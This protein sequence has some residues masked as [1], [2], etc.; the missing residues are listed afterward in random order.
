MGQVV[1]YHEVISVRV[2]GASAPTNRPRQWSVR[3][4]EA[5]APTE[6]PQGLRILKL[7]PRRRCALAAALHRP[8]K[9]AAYICAAFC[10]RV[11]HQRSVRDVIA[12]ATL[13]WRVLACFTGVQPVARVPGR[14]IPAG[15]AN[16]LRLFKRLIDCRE[17]KFCTLRNCMYG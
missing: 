8:R 11:G 1:S 15:A 16:S 14:E 6:R 2:N 5:S 10:K 4:N 7:A 17:R 13:C 12:L 3:A 9:P